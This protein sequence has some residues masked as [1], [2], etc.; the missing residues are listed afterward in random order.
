MAKTIWK[1]KEPTIPFW[2]KTLECAISR[3]EIEFAGIRK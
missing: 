1:L 3:S 2:S